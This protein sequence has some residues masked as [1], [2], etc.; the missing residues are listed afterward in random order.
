MKI[1]AM[2]MPDEH[3]SLLKGFIVTSNLNVITIAVIDPNMA[4][5]NSVVRDGTEYLSVRTPASNERFL[6]CLEHAKNSIGD[7]AWDAMRK[8]AA[9]RYK[10]ADMIPNSKYFHVLKNKS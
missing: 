4:I 9:Q 2:Y 10:I 1:K 3:R 8:E 5:K 7:H 6:T